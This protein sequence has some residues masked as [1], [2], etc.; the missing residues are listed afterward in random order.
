MFEVLK[1]FKH[2]VWRTFGGSFFFNLSFQLAFLAIF[3]FVSKLFFGVLGEGQ[4]LDHL[5]SLH[6]TRAGNSPPKIALET[7]FPGVCPI[8]FFVQILILSS[9]QGTF[10]MFGLQTASRFTPNAEIFLISSE[11][12]FS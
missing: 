8:F 7:K 5:S 9:I 12:A 2:V 6:M 10:Q 1:C 4:S 11:H 3:W